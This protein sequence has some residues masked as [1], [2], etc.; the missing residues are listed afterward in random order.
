[1]SKK[2]WI[3]I[4]IGL[5]GSLGAFL[6]NAS[7]GL[8]PNSL[9]H[10]RVDHPARVDHAKELFGKY[11][12]DSVVRRAEYVNGIEAF[13]LAR[14]T[15][16]LPTKWKSQA[17]SITNIIVSEANHAGMDPIFVLSVI[18][19]ESRLNP[20]AL[21]RHGEIGLMQLKPD[22]AEWIARKMNLP[23]NGPDTLR[24]PAS[25]VQLGMAYL[26]HLRQRYD[27]HSRFYISA[28]NMGPARLNKLVN[29]DVMPFTYASG[30]MG[31]YS[32]LY[33]DLVRESLIRAQGSTQYRVA[34]SQ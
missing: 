10:A 20:L 4:F 15:K 12:Q 29:Q 25:N 28:Y 14:V 17:K 32:Q 2:V 11:Y 33:T 18:T 8:L 13:I 3:P 6:L 26:K 16:G 31:I 22:T 1:M 30:V 24:D 5:L 21:G 27:K 23:W 34:A 19:R 7:A 9:S